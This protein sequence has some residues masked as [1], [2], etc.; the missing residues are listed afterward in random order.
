MFEIGGLNSKVVD[1]ETRLENN[2]KSTAEKATEI[3]H[4]SESCATKVSEL[5]ILSR[6]L[7]EN[8]ELKESQLEDAEIAISQLESTL[9]FKSTQI[10]TLQDV[11]EKC[12]SDVIELETLSEEL[13]ETLESKAAELEDAKKT[14]CT[15]GSSGN[16]LNTGIDAVECPSATPKTDDR[17]IIQDLLQDLG[18]LTT[19]LHEAQDQI[20]KLE[21]ELQVFGMRP[22]NRYGNTAHF[23]TA[24][25]EVD[26][27]EKAL[28][29]KVNQDLLQAL[30]RKMRQYYEAQDQGR[31]L[32]AEV[33]DL[34]NR[35]QK[36]FPDVAKS[37]D[38]L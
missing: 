32:K 8:L 9:E 3:Q 23:S 24:E 11:L 36:D 19:Q 27:S 28:L 10:C 16:R 35:L 20:S 7:Q 31:D 22:E 12:V 5:E 15:V 13:I 33:E 30:E 26:G 2:Q 4:A 17:R 34:K 25:P 14:I 6:E 38:K 1:L 21:A 29:E 18:S 37:R